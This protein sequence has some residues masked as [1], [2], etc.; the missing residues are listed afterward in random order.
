[1]AINAL[2]LIYF[3]GVIAAFIYGL[4]LIR[5]MKGINEISV[6]LM[7]SV[8]SWYGM[9]LMH[10]LNKFYDLNTHVKEIDEK[11]ENILKLVENVKLDEFSKID[12]D[13]LET[14]KH[15]A[16]YISYTK[17]VQEHLQNKDTEEFVK[18]IERK[19]IEAFVKFSIESMDY[20]SDYSKL[21]K[22]EKSEL[23]SKCQ[24]MFG[25]SLNRR[26]IKKHHEWNTDL[27]IDYVMKSISLI[28]ENK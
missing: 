1:M 13:I 7:L 28:R 5:K 20:A 25:I 10:E 4:I 6:M 19:D 15:D 12:E 22:I 11:V 16:N 17:R 2:L 27:L 26:E 14:K 9:L 3:A 18:N 8:L 23:V 21:D 24:N